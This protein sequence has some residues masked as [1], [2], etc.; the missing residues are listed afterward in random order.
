MCTFVP[1]S[2]PLAVIWVQSRLA[3][4]FHSDSLEC[5]FQKKKNLEKGCSRRWHFCSI[6]DVSFLGY[7]SISFLGMRQDTRCEH[8]PHSCLENR[9]KTVT[10]SV[11]VGRAVKRP[12][13]ASWDGLGSRQ[14]CPMQPSG[15][16]RESKQCQADSNNSD[17][18]VQPGR[19]A[20]SHTLTWMF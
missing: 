3:Q 15:E 17:Y 7:F 9:L 12:R 13:S 19:E 5:L 14:P 10:T 16:R 6:P 2:A 4:G 18:Q 1:V 11:V 20:Q 8:R